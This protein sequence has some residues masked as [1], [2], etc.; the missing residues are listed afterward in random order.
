MLTIQ[1]KVQLELATKDPATPGKLIIA[2]VAAQPKLQ[3]LLDPSNIQLFC[4]SVRVADRH[5]HAHPDMVDET[6][7]Y[8][9]LILEQ[10]VY[11]STPATGQSDEARALELLLG[12][13]GPSKST[14]LFDNLASSPDR[15]PQNPDQRARFAHTATRCLISTC[16]SPLTNRR[17]AG[18]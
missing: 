16:S 6:L 14:L 17:F 8:E 2:L 1:I 12:C 11:A 4:Q 15:A 13:W 9:L 3:G 18:R 10:T 7:L 5:L